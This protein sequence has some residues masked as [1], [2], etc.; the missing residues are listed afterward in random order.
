V[1]APVGPTGLP[2]N[3]DGSGDPRWH[4]GASF[5]GFRSTL[6]LGG[7]R[8]DIDERTS[9]ATLG[10]RLGNRLSLD[11]AA[12]AVLD[13]ALG[14]EDVAA[15]PAF[16]AGVSWLALPET[17]ARPFVLVSVTLSISTVS[18]PM[19]QVTAG[20]ARAGLLVGKTFWD[21]FTPYA[22]ARAFGGPVYHRGEVGSDVHHYT[23]GAGARLALPASFDLYVEGM[24]LGEQSVSAGAGVT[25]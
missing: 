8:V 25:F 17:S 21:R 7:E 12:G 13:G 24:A 10:Y 23:V 19:G 4:A 20:D 14:A 18:A 5:G 11:F 22:A 1:S 6:R 2:R 9:L 3:C 15:G 16:S